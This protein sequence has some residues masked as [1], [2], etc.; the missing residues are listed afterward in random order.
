MASY[1]ALADASRLAEI[2]QSYERVARNRTL[3][4]LLLIALCALS[5]SG[6]LYIADQANSGGFWTGL[7]KFFDY[8]A[9]LF[10]GAYEKGGMGLFRLTLQYLPYLFETLNIALVSTLLA[11][12][13][14]GALSFV[15]SRTLV[16]N[17][18]V[19]ALM[20]RVMDVFR[21]FPEIVI[22]LLLVLIFG[23]SPV[24]AVIA[25][26][27]HTI[28]ALAKQFS[29]VNENCDLKAVEGI[30]SMGGN[31]F[32]QI[33]FGILPQVLPNFL[34]YAL[35]RLEVNVRASAILGFVGA[36]GLGAELKMVVDWNYGADILVIIFMLVVSIAL[37]DYLSGVLRHKLIG[38]SGQV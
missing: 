23:P 25:V 9:E 4:T 13:L 31:W 22:A 21:A 18:L 20:R 7:G 34:S 1:P 29:E 35:L 3:Y 36:G 19:V 2:S 24:A 27:T 26:T 8:P 38:Q 5:I 33:R 12:F 16:S 14:G 28:G 6:G 15:A 11:F 10:L 17:R 32:E 37:I 30:R